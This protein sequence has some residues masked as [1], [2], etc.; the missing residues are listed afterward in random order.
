MTKEEF[1]E[2]HAS[3][4][5]MIR[6][7]ARLCVERESELHQ[8]LKNGTITHAEWE[9]GIK[10]SRRLFSLFESQLDRY[11]ASLKKGSID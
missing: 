5:K 8:E 10:E 2:G 1:E 11:T 7:G 9:E 6:D 3:L 4:L